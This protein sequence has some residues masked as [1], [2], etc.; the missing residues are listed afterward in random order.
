MEAPTALTPSATAPAREFT[1]P[2]AATNVKLTWGLTAGVTPP[3]T[4][5]YQFTMTITMGASSLSQFS[6]I[7]QERTFKLTLSADC[8]ETGSACTTS[9]EKAAARTWTLT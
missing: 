8:V 4:G 5:D 1:V 7:K 6:F 9:C 3:P 2:D